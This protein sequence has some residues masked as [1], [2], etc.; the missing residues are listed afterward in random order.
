M[1]NSVLI[2]QKKS[3]RVAFVGQAIM[4]L[5]LIAYTLFL[6]MPFYTVI[7]TAITANVEITATESFIWFPSEV[8]FEGFRQIFS[9]TSTGGGALFVTGFIN[10]LWQTLLPLLIGLTVSGFA[11]YCY[12]KLRFPLKEKLFMVEIATMT[13]PLGAFG[14]ISYLFYAQLG[15]ENTSLPIIIPGMFGSATVIFFLRMY[16]DGIP[17]EIMEAASIDGS[18]IM[19]NYITLILPIALPAFIAQF[20]FGFVGGYNNYVSALL[21]LSARR[22]LWPLQLVLSNIIVDPAVSPYANAK[23]AAAIAGM[24]PLI[25]MYCFLQRFFISGIAV[26]GSKE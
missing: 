24:F 7:A 1:R 20:I 3:H 26:G 19:R 8:S 22:D 4:L 23:C 5:C 6:F 13:L 17:N 21:Y 12:S 2:Y 18:G 10:T 11:A 16:F 14:I 9:V 15:W 25:V